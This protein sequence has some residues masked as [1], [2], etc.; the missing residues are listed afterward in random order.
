MKLHLIF[1]ISLFLHASPAFAKS[2]ELEGTCIVFLAR[3]A[4][5]LEQSGDIPSAQILLKIVEYTGNEFNRKYTTNLGT[6]KNHGLLLFHEAC[7]TNDIEKC[8]Q[9]REYCAGVLSETK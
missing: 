7:E 3:M 1:L 4:A 2:E 6:Y 9:T 8:I 5:V